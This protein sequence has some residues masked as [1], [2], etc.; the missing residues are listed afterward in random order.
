[1]FQCTWHHD[2]DIKGGLVDFLASCSGL[3]AQT[4]VSCL[5]SWI[6]LSRSLV[7]LQVTLYSR[8]HF[9]VK[10]LTFTFRTWN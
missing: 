9:N 1:M 2:H 4:G 7:L 6:T 8:V 3:P 5:S 10:G